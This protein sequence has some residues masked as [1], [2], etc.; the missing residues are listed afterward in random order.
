M[1]VLLVLIAYTYDT[2]IPSEDN[3][4]KKS[5][6]A[7]LMLHAYIYAYAN[8]LVKASLDIQI[9]QCMQTSTSLENF[10]IFGTKIVTFTSHSKPYIY[11]QQGV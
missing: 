1:S 3:I 7:L 9:M 11:C 4:R 2:V 6:F 10:S 5:V 8:A